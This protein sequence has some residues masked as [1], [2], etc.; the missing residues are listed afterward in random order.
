MATR[1]HTRK[2]NVPVPDELRK[3]VWY[4]GTPS[5]AAAKGIIKSGLMPGKGAGRWAHKKYA[6]LTPL[7]G[8]VYLTRDEAEALR[9]AGGIMGA[10]TAG[11]WGYVFEF[12]GSVLQDIV[13]DEDYVG[14]AAWGGLA[15][16]EDD[17]S[18]PENGEDEGDSHLRYF[19]QG[20]WENHRALGNRIGDVVLAKYPSSQYDAWSDL[21]IG[22]N[23]VKWGKKILPL[24]S[25]AD[26]TALLRAGA[27]AAHFGK[28]LKPTAAWR[29]R[30]T[31]DEPE[32]SDDEDDEEYDDFEDEDA[33]TEFYQTLKDGTSL[34]NLG[35]ERIPLK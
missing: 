35:A 10:A 3:D 1:T 22:F 23:L 27:P 18:S 12:P 6:D 24:L 32:E 14:A 21:A 20:I 19:A 11:D 16:N 8:A 34:R 33:E 13:P 9:Y 7:E 2:R 26:K 4:H 30:R 5:D 25:D 28:P 29:F 31:V 15:E 17:L